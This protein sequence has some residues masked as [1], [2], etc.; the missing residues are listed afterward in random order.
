MQGARPAWLGVVGRKDRGGD[1]AQSFGGADD[2]G[3]PQLGSYVG[4]SA[5]SVSIGGLH[6]GEQDTDNLGYLRFRSQ[7]AVDNEGS[8]PAAREFLIYESGKAKCQP[9]GFAPEVRPGL[10][11]RRP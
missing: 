2:P 11:P 8:R 3:Q 1:R 6:H 9:E 5:V 10:R 4:V 7:F